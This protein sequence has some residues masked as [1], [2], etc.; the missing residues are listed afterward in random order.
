[1][2]ERNATDGDRSHQGL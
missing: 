1:M 2:D